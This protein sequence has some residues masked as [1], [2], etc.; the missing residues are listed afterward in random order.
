MTAQ[1]ASSFTRAAETPL[2]RSEDLKVEKM[3]SIVSPGRA[4]KRPPREVMF[5]SRTT[6]LLS[7]SLRERGHNGGDD[8]ARVRANLDE[9]RVPNLEGGEGDLE[10]GVREESTRKPVNSSRDGRTA[11]PLGRSSTS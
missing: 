6:D 11:T 7:P 3:A 8:R 4:R 1:S 9:E 10:V 2:P 5:A